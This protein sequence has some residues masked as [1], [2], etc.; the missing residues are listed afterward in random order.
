MNIV[1][2]LTSAGINIG[3]C[4]ICFSLYSILRKQPGIVGVYFAGR[5]TQAQTQL[6]DG[7][8]SI[9]RFVPSAS[10]IWK[11]WETSEEELLVYAG[12]DAVVF[13]KIVVFRYFSFFG[14]YL[15][16]YRVYS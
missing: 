8:D 4:V 15:I 5:V 2:L 1:G 13:I 16:A 11:A 7:E 12:L 10:W 6:R 9:E 3:V 14:N